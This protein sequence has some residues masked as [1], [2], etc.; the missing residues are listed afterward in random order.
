MTGNKRDY[1]NTMIFQPKIRLML[2][3]K[4]GSFI[5]GLSRKMQMGEGAVVGGRI[6]LK[7]EPDLLSLL[8]ES[9]TSILVSGTN[10]KT[11]TTKLLSA[12]LS[13]AGSVVSNSAGAN[14]PAGLVAALWSAKA[15]DFAVLEVDEAHLGIVAPSVKPKVVVLLNLTRDQLDRVSE[16]RM[17]AKKWKDVLA[18][19]PKTVVVA[20]S[21]DP[22]VVWAVKSSPKVLWA[23]VGHSWISDANGCPNCGGKINYSE[24]EWHCSNCDLKKP[25]PQGYLDGNYFHLQDGT[26]YE[27]NLSLPGRVNQSNAAMAAMAASIFGLD[28]KSCFESMQSLKQVAG[29]Y[30]EVEIDGVRVRLLLAKNPAGWA[31]IFSFLSSDNI[32]VV[33]G[34][35]AQIADG[36]DPSW[37][38]DVEF[39]KFADRFV[40]ATGSRAYDLG[41]RLSYAEVPHEVEQDFVAAIKR[42][43][44]SRVD[45]IGN[46]TAFQQLRSLAKKAYK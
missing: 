23:Q 1:L 33:I 32:P 4:V 6:A 5:S 7:I 35:N 12:A 24:S 38:W 22:I 2:A 42:A 43:N 27:I 25:S 11:T 30:D 10:G 34:I 39:E 45:F 37:L 28:Y 19:I 16:V 46:Y 40:V 29:R 3:V 41:V 8:S 31:E 9:K 13:S 36:K 26:S 14:M 44:S 21:D 15:K 17:L 20:N 18:S